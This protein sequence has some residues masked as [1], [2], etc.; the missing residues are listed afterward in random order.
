M[1]GT[2]QTTIKKTKEDLNENV[3]PKNFENT[4]VKEKNNGVLI[5][6]SNNEKTEKI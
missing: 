1:I 4:D 2:Q 3:D 5:I 6:D